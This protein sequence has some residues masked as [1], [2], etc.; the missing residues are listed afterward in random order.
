MENGPGARDVSARIQKSANNGAIHAKINNLL[1]N[2]KTDIMRSLSSQLD[3]LQIK[4]KHDEIE[5][6]VSIFYPECRKKHPLKECPLNNIEVCA[7]CEQDHPT[8][9]FPSLP[10]LKAV[11]KGTTEETEQDYFVA[12]KKK[13]Q[14]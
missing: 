9:L 13:W 12:P 7:P 8:Q 1:E 10:R 14:Q 3:E 6:A 4:K 2:F 11:L 5:K